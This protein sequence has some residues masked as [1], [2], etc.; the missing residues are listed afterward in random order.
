MDTLAL[1]TPTTSLPYRLQHRLR[2]RYT[3]LLPRA[4]DGLLTPDEL[5]EFAVLRATL[6]AL[7]SPMYAFTHAIPRSLH[8]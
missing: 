5:A 2:L 3:D 1:E 4:V 8:V 7:E 6:N